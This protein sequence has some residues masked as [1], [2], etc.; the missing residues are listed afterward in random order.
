MATIKL[1]GQSAPSN[2]L[3]FSDSINIAEYSDSSGGTRSVA[4]ITPSV[5]AASADSQYYLVVND[6]SVTNVIEA[7]NSNNRR[8]YI[9]D[10]TTTAAH[11]ANALNNCSSLY[12]D[13]SIFPSGNSVCLS[14]RTVGSKP[15]VVSGNLPI[16]SAYTAGTATASL[17]GGKVG[18]QVSGGGE[19]IR[20]EKNYYGGDIGYNVSPIIT[21]IAEYG[22]VTPFS[23]KMY[24][25]DKDGHYSNLLGTMN[26]YA[27]YGYISNDS[28]PY[29]PFVEGGMILENKEAHGAKMKFYVASV[30]TD[31]ANGR[32][33]TFPISVAINKTGTGAIGTVTAYPDTIHGIIME[34]SVGTGITYTGYGIYDINVTLT[35]IQTMKRLVISLDAG[36]QTNND[37]ETIEYQIINPKRGAWVYNRVLWRNEYGGV[38]FFD[39]TEEPQYSYES[40][41][42]TYRK[43]FYGFYGNVNVR[44]ESIPYKNENAT[45]VKLGSHLMPVEGTYIA[46]S[47]MKSK[48]VWVVEG[49]LT[50][51]IIPKGIEITEAENAQYRMYLTYEYS[52]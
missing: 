9:S 10:R 34:A 7:N 23:M 2:M 32:T 12:A 40:S 36:S 16:T 14:A 19:F 24:S 30:D 46:D 17:Y 42:E 26:N 35:G 25:F 13:F 15:I 5:T 48:R 21:S 18:L 6:E 22:K 29:L 4:Y 27:T 45:Q 49:G 31:D 3:C 43:N 38:S 41:N 28:H 33:L 39:F 8:F 52:M 37:V 20:L 51:Y 47:L 50:R 44:Q 11:L 1:N